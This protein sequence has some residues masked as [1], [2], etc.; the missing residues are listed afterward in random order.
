MCG[1]R[2]PRQGRGSLG[3]PAERALCTSTPT[4]SWWGLN[5]PT[6]FPRRLPGPPH[7]RGSGHCGPLPTRGQEVHGSR[8]PGHRVDTWLSHGTSWVRTVRCAHMALSRWLRKKCSE[9][10]GLRA[11][12]RSGQ[13]SPC[14][15][16]PAA[17]TCT[18]RHCPWVQTGGVAVGPGPQGSASLAF[19]GQGAARPQPPRGQGESPSWA[20]GRT[21][22]RGW[23]QLSAPRP[24][25][26]PRA[27]PQSPVPALHGLPGMHPRPGAAVRGGPVPSWLLRVP[28][29]TGRGP[30][31]HLPGWSLTCGPRLSS[32]RN[33]AR[34]PGA[35][36]NG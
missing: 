30:S 5:T 18:A 22:R 17:V 9:V 11:T 25:G 23:G 33:S 26:H 15:G 16:C 12:G 1:T 29:G 4:P 7:R 20:P 19:Q 6:P 13:P 8:A 31:A 36:T 14:A 28:G 2:A 34:R 27:S 10:A 32:S 21:W 3:R 24:P 35:W